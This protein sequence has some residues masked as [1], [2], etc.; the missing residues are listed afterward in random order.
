MV[1]FADTEQQLYP[2]FVKKWL[3]EDDAGMNGAGDP[4]QIHLS[5]GKLLS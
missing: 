5:R 1:S 4:L 3:Q 2:Q